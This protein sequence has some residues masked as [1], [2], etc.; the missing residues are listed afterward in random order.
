MN[1]KKI[2]SFCIYGN[3]PKYVNAALK[4][5]KL[6]EQYYPDWICRFYVDKNIDETVLKEL[7]ET[8]SEVIIKEP[9]KGHL[10][11]L[12]RFEPLKDKTIDR[13]IVR[14]T[15]SR[16]NIRE[17]EAVNEWIESGK[18][19]HIIRDHIQHR[20]PIVG[21]LWGAS[22]KF[23]N[24]IADKYDHMIKQYLDSLDPLRIFS[25]PRGPYFNTDQPFLW[26]YIWPMIINT[27]IA[28]IKNIP[29]LKF[30]GNEKILKYEL[31]DNSFCGQD[32]EYDK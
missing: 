16:L 26:K 9:V 27:H 28:H 15:D 22:Y 30:T 25:H 14:D 6:Q 3:N 29:E 5:I 2:I 11:M 10:G 4:N 31:P 1:S 24:K 32:L 21:G 19:F 18:E 12:N 13:F 23:I 20:A 7:K 8:P 17:A